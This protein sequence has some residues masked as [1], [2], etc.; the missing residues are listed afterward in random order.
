M[1]VAHAQHTY[2]TESCPNNHQVNTVGQLDGVIAVDKYGNQCVTEG[3]AN[4]PGGGGPP[5]ATA[6]NCPVTGTHTEP[7]APGTTVCTAAVEPHDWD[8]ALAISGA[9]ANK[10]Q[11][12][13]MAVEVASV[14]LMA[15]DYA[16]T[17]SAS[18]GT[19]ST[20]V[21]LH[22][23]PQEPPGGG[24][25]P[26]GT[27]PSGNDPTAGLLPPVGNGWANWKTAGLRALPLVGSISGTELLVTQS[28]SKA[29]GPG[30][31]LYGEHIEPGTTITEFGTGT[32]G[33]GT[34]KISKPQAVASEHMH[35]SGIPHRTK[36]FKTLSPS[37]GDDSQQV[38]DALNA[39]PPGEVVQLSAGVFHFANPNGGILM[40]GQNSC[41]LRGAGPGKQLNTAL[42]A[43][44]GK[45]TIRDCAAGSEKV[46]IKGDSF[47]VDSSATQL[48]QTDRTGSGNFIRMHSLDVYWG[49]S[50]DLAENAVQGESSIK[51]KV[52]PNPAIKPG[53]LV[54]VDEYSVNDPW[55]YKGADFHGFTRVDGRNI[56]ELKEASSI[57]ADGKTITFS[58]PIMF[59][60]QVQYQAQATP[61]T[62]YGGR[63]ELHA[64]GIED[65]FIWGGV[66]SNI[67][68]GAGQA[69]P[70][71][72]CWVHNVESAWSNGAHVQLGNCYHCEI[73]DVYMHETPNPI[74]GGGGYITTAS[75]ATSESLWENDI[76]WYGNKYTVFQAAGGGNVLAYNYGD[77][78]LGFTYPDQPEGGWN[79]AH[80]YVTHLGLFE[81]NY[82]A[83]FAGD[84][85]WGNSIT[86]TSLRNWFSGLRGSS[87]PNKGYAPLNTW[88]S[89]PGG[90]GMSHY[91]DYRADSRSPVQMQKASYWHS[92]IGNILGM[93]DQ[94]LLSATADHLDQACPGPQTAF[95]VQV[96][97]DEEFRA[98][99]SQ[100]QVPMWLY[101]EWVYGPTG[102]L[103]FDPTT[104]ENQTRLFNWDWVS[105][106]QTCYKLGSAQ[107]EACPDIPLP[108]SFYIASNE[109]P[110]FFGS[111]PWPWVDPA[112]GAT[113]VLPAKYCFE[114]H[115]MPNCL[116]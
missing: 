72:Y 61:F 26:G 59:P 99:Q 17:L 48:V 97:T 7:V 58:T 32:G 38:N 68:M 54:V 22:V 55:A 52:A 15:G 113:Q 105:R 96:T 5:E 30:Q 80:Q 21:V 111:H 84:S 53:D 66:N 60:Y 78:S 73:S 82:G 89:G 23:T 44:T 86:M 46:T 110:K 77:D 102:E 62:S 20:N 49:S 109:K 108:Y 115:K 116:E 47:C 93:E 27:P 18:P 37:G 64:V 41:T 51:L 71:A 33:E 24:G 6:I 36:V 90:C 34:Y 63:P 43:V 16:F 65:L 2:V 10:F 106:K 56:T 40:S 13:G 88:V 1:G 75:Y 25:P 12:S 19:A 103:R 98:Q 81:G 45:S 35:A 28:F 112:T 4:P 74:N 79:Q 57:S 39:C 76:M 42:N 8:G 3:A 83:N 29:L 85:Y 101:G 67:N 104:I 100:A 9:D 87:P 70:C 31:S 14:P 11:H 50:T 114:Q 107:T 91:G 94:K 95:V 69:S 92:F